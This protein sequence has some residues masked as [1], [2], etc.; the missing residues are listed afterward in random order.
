M[1][2]QMNIKFIEATLVVIYNFHLYLGHY[3]KN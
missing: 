1:H 3:L 2:G